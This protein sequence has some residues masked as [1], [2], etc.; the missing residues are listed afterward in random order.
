MTLDDGTVLVSEVAFPPGHD[1]NPLTDA[2][3]A[4]KFHGLADPALGAERADA[5]LGPALGARR[6]PAAARG[7]RAPRPCTGLSRSGLTPFCESVTAFRPER[8]SR[9]PA[10]CRTRRDRRRS[11]RS[12]KES[13]MSLASRLKSGWPASTAERD[14]SERRRPA[15]RRVRR[16]GL[17]GRSSA[18]RPTRTACNTTP[19]CSP[20]AEDP[21]PRSTSQLVPTS[22]RRLSQ[23]PDP[24]FHRTR[25]R[26]SSRSAVE[27]F[28]S[29]TYQVILGP[30]RRRCDEIAYNAEQIR[31]GGSITRRHLLYTD[32]PLARVPGEHAG[33]QLDFWLVLHRA[34]LLVAV[35]TAQG[36]ADR[37]PRRQQRGEPR[38]RAAHVRLPVHV[39]E[40][41]DRRAAP[42]AAP[43]AVHRD[44]RRVQRGRSRRRRG[45]STTSTPRCPTS[46]RSP[47]ARSTWSTPASRSSTSRSRR[48][49]PCSARSTGS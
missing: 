21:R 5:T 25:A 8:A 49:R 14:L 38:G 22:S 44:L 48:R 19:A 24:D 13:R 29:L 23:A 43:R 16:P 12:R 41:H 1:K 45:R 6:R 9:P 31:C 26:P 30:P 37:R 28:V 17:P 34:R 35:A 36:R 39:Q 27:D 2:Q 10:G 11:A 15:R 42:R 40:P 3:L 32:V 20:T 7:D 46:R 47:T 4:A 18:A 33:R